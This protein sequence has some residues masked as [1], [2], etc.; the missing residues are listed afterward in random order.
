MI[1]AL[2]PAIA[3]MAS[4]A[5]GSAQAQASTIE[6][7]KSQAYA[8]D[9]AQKFQKE[10]LNKELKKLKPY[11][12]VGLKR[13]LP[14]MQQILEQG[15]LSAGTGMAGTGKPGELTLSDMP[16]YRMQRGAG[17]QALE[18]AGFGGSDYVRNQYLGDLGTAENAAT[19]AR[20]QDLLSIGL[21]ASGSAGQGAQSYATQTGQRMSSLANILSSAQSQRSLIEQQGINRLGGQISSIPSYLYQQNRGQR[22]GYTT[23][24]NPYSAPIV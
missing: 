17:L 3:G 2:I 1:W 23:Y 11:S 16:F 9:L 4:Q 18:E 24:A 22:G 7:A 15:D 14:F 13:G 12:D 21:G 6:A 8:A 19:R 5:A 10:M 20:L